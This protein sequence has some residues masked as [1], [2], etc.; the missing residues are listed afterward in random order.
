M[1]S[2]FTTLS[3]F[4]I[5]RRFLF[6]VAATDFYQTAT[7]IYRAQLAKLERVKFKF[8]PRSNDTKI[9]KYEDN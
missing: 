7:P 6:V 3:R 4:Y 2:L 5:E 8:I 9:E 1:V